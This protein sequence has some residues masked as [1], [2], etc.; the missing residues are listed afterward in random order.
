MSSLERAIIPALRTHCLKY[1]YVTVIH[2]REKVE[3]CSDYLDIKS[4]GKDKSL[5]GFT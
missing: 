3:E 5:E 4:E 2:M 1:G